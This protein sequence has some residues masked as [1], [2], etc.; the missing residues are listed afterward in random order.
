MNQEN[1]LKSPSIQVSKDAHDEDNKFSPKITCPAL[2]LINI[3]DGNI[4]LQLQVHRDGTNPNGVGSELAVFLLLES[5]FCYSW[6]C[7]QLI[8]I[9]CNRRVCEHNTLTPRI[10]SHMCTHF[11]LVLVHRMAQ[12]VAARVFIKTCSS[13][14]HHVSDRSF[15]LHP[16]TSSSLSLECHYT[17]SDFF[18]SSIMVIFLHVVGTAEYKN[19]CAHAE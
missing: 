18:I 4:G 8:A 7:L 16:L 1:Q 10:F 13:T 14:C 3:Q 11:I 12:G 9:H 6:F 5:L 19:P 2:G 15:S 17:F